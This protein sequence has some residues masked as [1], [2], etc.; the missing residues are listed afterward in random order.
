MRRTSLSVILEEYRAETQELGSIQAGLRGGHAPGRSSRDSS[1]DLDPEL[2][3]DPPHERLVFRR[4]A[5]VPVLEVLP[6]RAASVIVE[7]ITRLSS[8]PVSRSINGNRATAT[9]LSRSCVGSCWRSG[10]F[11]ANHA[12][13][14]MPGSRRAV[15]VR[16]SACWRMAGA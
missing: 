14:V 2:P 1:S 7:P 4:D 11:S 13:K 9:T 5:G 16:S 15:A 10:S 12:G 8:S 3:G 6:K